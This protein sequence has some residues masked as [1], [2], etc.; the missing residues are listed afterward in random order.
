MLVLITDW[1]TLHFRPYYHTLSHHLPKSVAR[2]QS[3]KLY[4]CELGTKK[5][6]IFVKYFLNRNPTWQVLSVSVP[7]LVFALILDS[8]LNET[9]SYMT[10][11]SFVVWIEFMVLTS[12]QMKIIVTYWSVKNCMGANQY[13]IKI[14]CHN[15]GQK[16]PKRKQHKSQRA[17]VT[18][19]NV[20]IQ[21][22]NVNKGV[23]KK[24]VCKK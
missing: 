21:R 1:Q 8:S 23:C 7:V 12:T 24:V 15:E 4:L 5:K 16:C 18:Q 22:P 13:M 11:L 14:L 6:E 9:L 20:C 19:S 2:P 10:S 3:T 17:N